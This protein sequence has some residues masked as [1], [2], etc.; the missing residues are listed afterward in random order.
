MVFKALEMKRSPTMQFSEDLHIVTLWAAKSISIKEAWSGCEL[1][2]KFRKF[3][4]HG[5]VNLESK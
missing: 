5:L 2:I 4:M 1:L 3:T